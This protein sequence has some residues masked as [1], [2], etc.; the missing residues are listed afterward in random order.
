MKAGAGRRNGAIYL[1]FFSFLISLQRQI[2]G[3]RPK[4]KYHD[5]RQDREE[6]KAGANLFLYVTYFLHHVRQSHFLTAKSR[7][8]LPVPLG[9]LIGNYVGLFPSV[10]VY[11]GPSTCIKTIVLWQVYMGRRRR[12]LERTQNWVR[13]RVHQKFIQLHCRYRE[14][15][16][17]TRTMS[18]SSLNYQLITGQM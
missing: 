6:E 9:E 4:C 8:Q 13:D 16:S 2:V 1:H 18:V 3:H 7:C 10:F 5:K 12:A 11:L 15:V 14:R 17:H